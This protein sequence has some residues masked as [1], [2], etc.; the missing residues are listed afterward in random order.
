LGGGFIFCA[1][2]L[3]GLPPLSGFI[4]KFAIID[5]LFA[6]SAVSPTAWLLIAIIIVSGLATLISMTRAGIDLLWTPGEDSP[7]S[8]SVIEVAPVGLLLAA[9]LALMLQAGPVYLYME[10]TASELSNP[11]VYTGSVRGAP[12]AGEGA[13]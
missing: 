5:A 13:P 2:L 12:R 11:S 10:G 8:L 7:P 1:L 6:G 3:A 9:C 4:A